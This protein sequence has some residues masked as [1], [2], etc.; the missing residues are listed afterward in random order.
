MLVQTK[1]SSERSPAQGG[2]VCR[3]KQRRRTLIRLAYSRKIVVNE[4]DRNRSF[5]DCRRNALDIASA[6]IADCK[7]AGQARFE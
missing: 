6:Y 7:N 2:V 4:T 1:L 5:S 3:R